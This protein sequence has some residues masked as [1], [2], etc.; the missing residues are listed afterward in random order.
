MI[1]VD[2]VRET[3]VCNTNIREAS[4]LYRKIVF[5]AIGKTA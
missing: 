2:K 1:D 4:L 3:V 5:T